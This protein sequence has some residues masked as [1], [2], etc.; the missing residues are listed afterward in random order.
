MTSLSF[1]L[2]KSRMTRAADPGSS[3]EKASTSGPVKL[4]R[5][6]AKSVSSRARRASVLRTTLM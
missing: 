4:S 2:A 1:P 3:R 6:Q 5:M